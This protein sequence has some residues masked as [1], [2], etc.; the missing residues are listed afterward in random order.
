[1]FL[2]LARLR[3]LLQEGHKNS[4][5]II[6]MLIIKSILSSLS[7]QRMNLTCVFGP[8]KAQLSTSTSLQQATLKRLRSLRTTNCIWC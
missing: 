4:L 1:M 6:E 8:A 7:T 5:M 2:R 3:C